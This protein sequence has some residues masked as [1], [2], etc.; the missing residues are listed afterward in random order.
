MLKKIFI[1]GA[2]LIFMS[3]ASYAASQCVT[4]DQVI[5]EVVAGNPGLEYKGSIEMADKEEI[6]AFTSTLFKYT[7]PGPFKI[8]DIA[9]IVFSTALNDTWKD[10]VGF[11]DKNGCKLAYIGI[12]HKDIEK[13][14]KE[15]GGAGA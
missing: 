2:A 10:L 1:A 9:K 13:I 7:G 5:K 12:S 3:T 6:V 8:E 14:L 15:A 4:S 11:Y